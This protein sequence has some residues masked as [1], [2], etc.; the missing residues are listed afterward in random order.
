MTSLPRDPQPAPPT[1]LYRTASYSLLFLSS[2]VFSC[3][4][5]LL[6]WISLCPLTVGCRLS[7]N[8]KLFLHHSFSANQDTQGLASATKRPCSPDPCISACWLHVIK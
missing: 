3:N 5:T 1:S 7:Y 4:T 2:L 6:D 8:T